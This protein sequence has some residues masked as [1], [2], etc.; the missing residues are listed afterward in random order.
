MKA[1]TVLFLSAFFSGSFVLKIAIFEAMNKGISRDT[2]AGKKRCSISFKGLT[3]P[4]IQSMVV[5]TSPIGD[6]APPALAAMMTKPANHMRSSLSGTILR[7]MEMSTIVAVRLSMME[8]STKA[9]VATTSSNW[10]AVL[11]LMRACTL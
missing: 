6:H 2:K 9:R 8:E 7:K 3:F 1:E 5:V 4:A 11:T 10:Y